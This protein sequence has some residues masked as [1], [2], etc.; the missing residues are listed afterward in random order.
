M[1]NSYPELELLVLPRPTCPVLRSFW[2]ILSLGAGICVSL[3]LSS[4][5]IAN[6]LVWGLL[7]TAGSAVPGLI[8]PAVAKGPYWAWDRLS[9]LA[10]RAVRLWLSLI[11]FLIV[12][13]VGRAS[14]LLVWSAPDRD[15]SGWTEK[16]PLPPGS[17]KAT[18]DLSPRWGS[19]P[20]WIRSLLVWSARSGNL[21]IWSLLPTFALLRVVEGGPKSSLGGNVYTLY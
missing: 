7:T 3:S 5:S 18:S 15:A 19:G 4:F 1:A 12:S 6:A 10:R 13:V 9:G 16:H 8:R 11:A 21:W 17:Y 2:L 20:G 14:S